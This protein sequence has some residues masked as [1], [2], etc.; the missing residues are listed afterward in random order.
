MS[1]PNISAREAFTLSNP[2]LFP[3]GTLG[4]YSSSGKTYTIPV[5]WIL[6]CTF[7]ERNTFSPGFVIAV[8]QLLQAT[9]TAQYAKEADDRVGKSMVH[10]PG[11]GFQ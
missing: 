9:E 10:I 2:F 11:H 7:N 8:I 6:S 5:W 3:D 1:A 4:A